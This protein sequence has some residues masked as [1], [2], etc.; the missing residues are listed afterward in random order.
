MFDWDLVEL[1]AV[2][3]SVGWMGPEIPHSD[4]CPG[5]AGPP[6]ALSQV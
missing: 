3:G 6:S 4:K 5:E 2:S 1:N